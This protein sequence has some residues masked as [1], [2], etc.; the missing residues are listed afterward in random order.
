MD[1]RLCLS[2]INP[3]LYFPYVS[4]PLYS[5]VKSRLSI[6]PCS[7]HLTSYNSVTLFLTFNNSLATSTILT[8][9]S[10]VLIFQFP[11][12]N[13]SFLSC[14]TCLYCRNR[15]RPVSPS[16]AFLVC[17]MRSAGYTLNPR[18]IGG[19]RFSV[20]V[21]SLSPLVRINAFGIRDSSPWDLTVQWHFL[22]FSHVAP[23]TRAARTRPHAAHLAQVPRDC[24]L[25]TYLSP[26]GI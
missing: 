5:K 2:N 26:W 23:R 25:P 13:F 10:I 4:G 22:H 14:L 7:F 8:T 9:Y 24:Y 21:V 20:R 12:F 16:W 15:F 11:I 3:T 6:L 18:Y 1:F 17:F 19:P